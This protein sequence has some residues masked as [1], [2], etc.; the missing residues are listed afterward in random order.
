MT[1]RSCT[2]TPGALFAQ[3]CSRDALPP[4]RGRDR[5]GSCLECSGAI[6]VLLAASAEKNFNDNE[7]GKNGNNVARKA[8][9]KR[10]REKGLTTVT[11]S[12]AKNMR[13]TGAGR[14]R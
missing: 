9:K 14:Q 10:E 13:V 4:P 12:K 3:R 11:Q 7:S 5:S 2:V 6:A 1:A 8:G